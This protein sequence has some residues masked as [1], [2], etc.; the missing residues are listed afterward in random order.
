MILLVVWLSD[1]LECCV[2]MY[3]SHIFNRLIG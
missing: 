2:Y 3:F 1:T